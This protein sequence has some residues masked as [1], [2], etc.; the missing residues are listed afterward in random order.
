M[1]YPRYILFAVSICTSI[2]SGA[3]NYDLELDG[4]YYTVNVSNRTA[5][6]VAYPSAKGDVV[7]PD[8]LS[9]NTQ[10]LKVVGI[11]DGVFEGNEEITSISCDEPKSI[12]KAAFSGCTNMVSI[13]MPCVFN[14]SI[15]E[16]TF[17]QCTSL[18][19]IASIEGSFTLINDEAFINCK[20]IKRFTIPK[21]VSFIS[22]RAFHGF[23]PEYLAIENDRYVDKSLGIL[24]ND[25]V[26]SI[27]LQADTIFWKR[28]TVTFHGVGTASAKVLILAESV[29]TI[30]A[31]IS[32]TEKVITQS[33]KPI[34]MDIS[35]TTSTYMNTPLY[36]PKGSLEQY[37]SQS[38]WWSN[39]FVIKEEDSTSG[40]KEI[41]EKTGNQTIYNI[42]GEIIKKTYKGV[43]IIKCP[44]GKIRKVIVE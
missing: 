22:T 25:N 33:P 27:L 42:Q 32:A 2:S 38:G 5:T 37:Q 15:P 6:V 40:I 31:P 1:R 35:F 18:E 43:N 21:S 14:S 17:S 30:S 44:G 23:N 34:Q 9:Y 19:R 20:S 24:T 12:G 36:V 16:K 26:Y 29:K 7:I 8:C 10:E 28:K 13:Q 3:F 11:G 41:Y 4:I 39:F